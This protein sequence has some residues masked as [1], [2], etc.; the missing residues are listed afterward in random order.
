MLR[1]LFNCDDFG[2]TPEINAAVL[3]AHREGVLGSA[4]LMVTGAALDE[5]VEIARANPS[6]RFDA[7]N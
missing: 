1:L 2:R 7:R 3:K 6:L 5:A 4:S